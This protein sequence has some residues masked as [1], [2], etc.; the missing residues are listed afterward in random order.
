MLTLLQFLSASAAFFLNLKT[1][2]AEGG[3]FFPLFPI[4]AL[5]FGYN[6]NIHAIDQIK[7]ME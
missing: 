3:N 4:Y 1:A 7:G 2:A 6:S 5:L